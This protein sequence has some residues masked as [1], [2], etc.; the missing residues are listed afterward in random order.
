MKKMS[1]K[2]LLLAFLFILPWVHADAQ[3]RT[4]ITGVVTDENSEPLVGTV[5][6]VKGA[7]TGTVADLDGKYSIKV[8]DGE[9]TLIFSFLGYQDVE[10]KT[11]G[12]VMNVQM[13]NVT[14][15]LDEVVIVGYGEMKKRDVTGA[16]SSV[17]SKAIEE[18]N[19]V[20]VMDA[21]Q[22]QI[23]GVEV[24]TAS[25]APGESAV[26]RVRGTA[27]F[28]AGA[29]PLYVV[30]GVIYDD[31]NDLNPDDIESIEVLKDAASASIYGSRSANGVFLITTKH[32]DTNSKLNLRYVRSYSQLIRKMPKANASERR[33][34]DAV[35]REITGDRNDQ[36]Y[37]FTIADSLAY[38]TNQD[39]DVQD[40]LFRTAVRNEINL[41][42]SGAAN[43]FNY[44]I[45]AGYL[46]DKG[47]IVN[48][49]YNR[50]TTRINA[51]YKPT[52]K[53]TIA[54]K[55][56][57]SYSDQKGIDE[58][59]VLN[60]LLER[61]PY[62]AIFNPDGSYVPNISSRRNP[63]AVAMTDYDKDQ[64]Y[65]ATIYESV[66]YQI[67]KYF[68]L[69]TSLQANYSNTRE[70]WYRPVA[71]LHSTERST[72]R[73][74]STV[75]YDW[76]NENYVSFKRTFKK[77]H[78]INAMLGCSFQSWYREQI[79]LV[80]LDYTTDEVFTLNA[81]SDFDVKSTYTREY[82]HRMA[83][84][85]G[86]VGYNY[87][88][89]YLFNANL[90]YDGSSR[91]GKNNRWG[92]FPSA[93]V[94]WRFSDEVFT[95]WM[96]PLVSDA[97]LR[98]SYGVTGNEQIGDYVGTL[99]YSPN[100]IYEDN[101]ANV[102]GIG[103]SNLGYDGLSWEETS[104]FNIGMDIRLLKNKIGIVADYYYK[105]TDKLLN[106]VQLPKETGFST[107]YKN[108]GS[109]SNEGFELAVNWDIIR[110]KTL[111]WTA[112]FNIATNNSKITEIADGI[113][114]YKGTG[115]AIYI[116]EG[117][118]LG[119]FYGY[120][121]KGI[122]AYDESNAYSDTWQQLTPV[123]NADG[124]FNHHELNGEVYTQTPK[125]KLASNGDVLRGGDVDL[126]DT[127]GDGTINMLDRQVI[128]C[129]QPDYFGGVSSTIS[130]KNFSL[131]VSIY[132]S[133]GGE[134]YNYAEY[135]RNQFRQDGATP[136]PDAIHNMWTK[137]GDQVR[138]PA[139]IISE[140]NTLAP[141]DFYMEDGSFI[142]LKNVK[143]SYDFPSKLLRKNFMKSASLYVY[144][145]N[146]LTFTD[147]TGYDPEFST[148]SDPLSM[149]IDTNK[150][151][152]KRELG[153]GIN[154]GF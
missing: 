125:Q 97:K 131:F 104:Q 140:H 2:F 153:V 4:Q 28:E 133:I 127:N 39:I 77:N 59:G 19:P 148:G 23:A 138:Y 27:T 92:A 12:K 18:Q 149:G 99:L 95:G 33:Y 136:S 111:R 116:K 130:Y 86:R 106:Q 54:S 40:L 49:S 5:I 88:S 60:Q 151:P 69:N 17:S 82:E 123:F 85:F 44:Y 122:Y 20:S 115:D 45:N 108:V 38:F 48:S 1:I 94:A 43:T 73:D 76:T 10:Q 9:V 139:P 105:K 46:N 96:K 42:A 32:G 71:Q 50:L 16:I 84:F 56:N 103:A 11:K 29:S 81:A 100:Y 126:Q 101:G 3:A 141:S 80:G 7:A 58:T 112:N 62:W 145:K 154:I 146:L 144:G 57:F 124:T 66:N 114:F 129:A 67:N 30:D 147:Y 53:L 128:G 90:R 21:L 36:A 89:R 13:T 6:K 118:R 78:T 55:I 64:N 152:R 110:K 25:G 14:K 142:K 37:G 8:P 98:V 117:A 91:F 47:I 137:P 75:R 107:M 65:K 113:P 83:S 72:G 102:A 51:E 135:K 34:Y 150:Y 70:K 119:E 120:R 24:V 134:I 79:R 22:G 132:Y 109:M 35:R 87:K 121:Y 26:I 61:V 15:E 93:S 41:S 74:Y 63:Y 143:L 68:S 52:K 31:I